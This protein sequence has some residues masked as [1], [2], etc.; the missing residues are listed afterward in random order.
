MRPSFS[1]KAADW[2]LQGTLFIQKDNSLRFRVVD[3]PND[4]RIE[5]S[6]HAIIDL[7][8]HHVAGTYSAT[9]TAEGLRVFVDGIQQPVELEVEN[10]LYAAMEDTDATFLIGAIRNSAGPGLHQLFTGQ[11]DELS[12]YRRALSATEIADIF[13]A[14]TAG[15]CKPIFLDTF[16]S[17][18]TSAWDQTLP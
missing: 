14:G 17:G 6:T 7:N 8:W 5:V 3:G 9:G 4:Y 12:I 1:S 10:P 11:L 16:E 18:D 13:Q 15:K 2:S